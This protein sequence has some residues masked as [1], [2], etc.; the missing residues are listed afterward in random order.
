MGIM[1]LMTVALFFFLPYYLRIFLMNNKKT[2]KHMA[3]WIITLSIMAL[4]E[5]CFYRH[6]KL[7]SLLILVF[8]LLYYFFTYIR[9]V[10]HTGQNSEINQ[11]QW[12]LKLKYLKKIAITI[13]VLVGIFA[14]ADIFMILFF[15]ELPRL[16][17]LYF[18]I[19]IIMGYIQTIVY[20]KEYFDL[21]I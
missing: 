6:L 7:V 10:R 21:A 11:V 19:L 12:I 14:V 20:G 13:M 17:R 4:I 5:Y 9:Y 16:F 15:Y 2:R 3:C 1:I 18:S 8:V